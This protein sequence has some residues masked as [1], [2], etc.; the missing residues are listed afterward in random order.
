MSLIQRFWMMIRPPAPSVRWITPCQTSS[1]ASVTTNDGT[2]MSATNEPWN[3]P[4][5]AATPSARTIGQ[6]PGRSWPLSGF[7]SSAHDDAGDAADVRDRE[8]D[9]ADQQHEDDAVG[10]HR[11]AR[12][13]HDDVVEVDG[14]EEVLRGEAEDDDDDRQADDHRP[15]AEVAALDVLPELGERGSRRAAATSNAG[16]RRSGRH[17]GAS[18]GMP[19]TFVGGPAVIACTTSCCVVSVR[20]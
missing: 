14:R 20:S 4:I 6:I 11:R 15:A 5:S 9:L 19:E 18:V 13:L 2:P 7:C 16:R 3:A 12:H 10:E 8:V 1:P 17:D